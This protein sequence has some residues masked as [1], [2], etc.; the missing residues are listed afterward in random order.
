MFYKQ[1][2][3]EFED[4]LDKLS[5][6]EMEIFCE[7]V[8]KEAKD[9]TFLQ[10][11]AAG[12]DPTNHLSFEYGRDN[13]KNHLA[14][15]IV[16]DVSGGISGGALGAATTA[17]GAGLMYLIMKKKNP[18]K[19]EEFL[20][21]LKDSANSLNPKKLLS[22]EKPPMNAVTA[23]ALGS[24]LIDAGTEIYSRDLQYRTGQSS[25]K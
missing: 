20:N 14:H 10:D 13:E 3:E 22:K 11:V 21:V 7:E 16:Q 25:K 17:G 9:S 18:T 4:L 15:R 6:E 8:L 1:A 2:L 19:A 5:S 24:G 12:I 23:T